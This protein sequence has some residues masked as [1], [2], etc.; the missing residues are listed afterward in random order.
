MLWPEHL[1]VAEQVQTPASSNGQ[2]ATG[3]S[4]LC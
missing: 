1:A 4:E 2:W 3:K